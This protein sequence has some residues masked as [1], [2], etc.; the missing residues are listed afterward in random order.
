MRKYVL[1]TVRVNQDT[2]SDANDLSRLGDSINKDSGYPWP[3]HSVPPFFD[4][5]PPH[6]QEL[7]RRARMGEREVRQS[8]WD[9]KGGEWVKAEEAR[10]RGLGGEGLKSR[11]LMNVD[12]NGDEEG[13]EEDEDEVSDVEGDGM[14]GAQGGGAILPKKRKVPPTGMDERI[15]EVKKWVQLPFDKADKMVEPKY[16]A[17]RRPGMENLYTKR[18]LAH[19]QGYGQNI[20]GASEVGGG[21]MAFDL[22]D[23]SGLGTAMGGAQTPAAEQGTPVRRNHPPKRKKKGGPGRK[24]KEVVEAERRAREEAER[25]ARGEAPTESA[26]VKEEPKEGVPPEGEKKDEAEGEGEE[27]SGDESEGEGSEEGEVNEEPSTAHATAAPVPPPTDEAFTA[28]A[29]AIPL[30]AATLPGPDPDP[31]VDETDPAQDRPPFIVEESSVK[32]EIDIEPTEEPDLLPPE[33][34]VVALAAE[35]DEMDT[36]NEDEDVKV[37]VPGEQSAPADANSAH[38]SPDAPAAAPVSET[39]E[40]QEQ[41]QAEIVEEV[42]LLGGLEAEID[43]NVKEE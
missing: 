21:G 39:A 15:F 7:L 23:G 38:T 30:A 9:K 6:N 29:A 31:V 13:D 24:K 12:A 11:Y 5:L 2:A 27:G 43:R 42:D 16:L 14:D 28:N 34:D 36:R 3:E 41:S 4:A 33:G 17:D 20:L 25:I 37:P 1:E 10:R 32:A 35:A 26:E 19:A 22:G 8:V 40:A 18:M